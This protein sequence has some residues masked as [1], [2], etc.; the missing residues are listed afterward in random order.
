MPVA[1]PPLLGTTGLAS[2]WEIVSMPAP[3]AAGLTCAQ[4]VR[5]ARFR[6]LGG[7]V[8]A[9]PVQVARHAS[10]ARHHMGEDDLVQVASWH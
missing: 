8:Q 3:A 6:P 4:V 7:F 9:G 2:G 1:P 10:H 5:M